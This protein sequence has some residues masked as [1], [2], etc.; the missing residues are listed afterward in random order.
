MRIAKSHREQLVSLIQA[1]PSRVERNST[2]EHTAAV[3]ATGRDT[4]RSTVERM[5][6]AQIYAQ[7]AEEPT[8]DGFEPS[9][10]LNPVERPMTE[11]ELAYE[12]GTVLDDPQSWRESQTSPADQAAENEGPPD[13]K[14]ATNPGTQSRDSAPLG[15]TVTTDT[16]LP[17]SGQK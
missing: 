2:V 11:H 17:E 1:D 8:D 9:P 7:H 14:A 15:G 13:E 4:L 3:P 6:G 10:D 12:V 5:M 16:N